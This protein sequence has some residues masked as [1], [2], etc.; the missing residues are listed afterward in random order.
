MSEEERN[1]TIIRR[2]FEEIWNSGDL[3][4]AN[5]IV[6]TNM[7]DHV[8]R[9]GNPIGSEGFKQSVN[10]FRSAF[11]DLEITNDDQIA[12]GDKVAVL[13]TARGTHLGELMGIAPTGKRIEVR[14]MYMYRLAGGKLVERAGARDML[15]LLQ[16]IGAIP[17]PG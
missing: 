13:W 12:A 9:P 16:Q 5:E 2:L 11:P 6:D 3:A 7:V 17:T 1:Q 14:G 8:T 4:V 15:G 10:M